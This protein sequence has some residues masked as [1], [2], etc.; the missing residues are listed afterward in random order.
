MRLDDPRAY[1]AF[2]V[3]EVQVRRA[4]QQKSIK[5]ALSGIEREAVCLS[6]SNNTEQN[7]EL[8][9]Y[10]DWADFI[11][12]L[13]RHGTKQYNEKLFKLLHIDKLNIEII[14]TS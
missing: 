8:C 5:S 1:E 6:R 2:V 14:G 10:L 3:Q 7:D 4:M 11:T 9:L 13:L 12:E